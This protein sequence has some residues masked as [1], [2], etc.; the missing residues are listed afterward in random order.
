M[1][2][3]F[4]VSRKW[5]TP[6]LLSY[7]AHL[8]AKREA[9]PSGHGRAQCPSLH[10]AVRARLAWHERAHDSGVNTAAAPL[11]ARKALARRNHTLAAGRACHW[12]DAAPHARAWRND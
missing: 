6:A 8:T 5:R 10:L 1:A 3:A 9:D 4:F 2:G 11:H 12:P 7:R